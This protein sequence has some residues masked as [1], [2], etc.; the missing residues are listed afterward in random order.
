VETIPGLEKVD[1]MRSKRLGAM[2]LLFYS[3]WRIHSVIL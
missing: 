3:D 2:S 1:R